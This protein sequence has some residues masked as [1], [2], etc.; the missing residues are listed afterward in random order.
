MSQLFLWPAHEW[1]VLGPSPQ[2]QP[3]C[4]VLGWPP[5]AHRLLPWLCVLAEQ[6]GLHCLGWASQ[7]CQFPT[8][9]SWGGHLPEKWVSYGITWLAY[10]RVHRKQWRVSNQITCP[11]FTRIPVRQSLNWT[12]EIWNEWIDHQPDIFQGIAILN[13]FF[14][15]HFFVPVV[16]NQWLSAI[17]GVD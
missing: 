1:R 10:C 6:A 15:N 8:C 9:V 12:S 3:H 2:G 14:C 4:L 17:T 5:E 13:A 11:I 16:T 7:V